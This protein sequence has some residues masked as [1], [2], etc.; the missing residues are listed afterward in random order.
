MTE[1]SVQFIE[2]PTPF[3]KERVEKNANV[4]ERI[5]NSK[6]FATEFTRQSLTETDGKTAEEI[7]RELQNAGQV[8]LK[9][10]FYR[11]LL[12]RAIAFERDGSVYLNTAK[13]ENGA[14]SP[15]NLAHELAHTLGYKHESNWQGESTTTVPYVVGYIVDRISTR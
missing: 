9:I 14:G 8:N 1:I 12:T 11:R 10:G 5:L 13:A 7:C 15:G 3:W 2:N 4:A 6:E